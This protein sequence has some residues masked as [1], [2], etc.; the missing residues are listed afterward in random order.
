M[1][2]MAVGGLLDVIVSLKMQAAIGRTV[3]GPQ[4]RKDIV[5]QDVNSLTTAVALFSSP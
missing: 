1:Y 2:E 5:V 4:Q 3:Q